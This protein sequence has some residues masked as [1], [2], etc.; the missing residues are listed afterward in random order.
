MQGGILG[1]VLS[2]GPPRSFLGRVSFGFPSI[3]R[4]V[5][6]RDP[7]KSVDFQRPRVNWSLLSPGLDSEWPAYGLYVAMRSPLN[8]RFREPEIPPQGNEEWE[9]DSPSLFISSAPSLGAL[10]CAHNC[11]PDGISSLLSFSSQYGLPSCFQRLQRSSGI[12]LHQR[13]PGD[14]S[15]QWR[16]EET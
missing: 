2:T 4:E 13:D 11:Y 8:L 14:P 16:E 12:L 1:A 6:L 7:V 10:T 15:L 9:Y 3:F 5:S